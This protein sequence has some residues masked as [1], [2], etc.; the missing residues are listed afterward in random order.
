VGEEVAERSSACSDVRATFGADSIDSEAGGS[1]ALRFALTK[2]EA[3]ESA[4]A[5]G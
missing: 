3:A 5:S 2:G 1:S 4:I